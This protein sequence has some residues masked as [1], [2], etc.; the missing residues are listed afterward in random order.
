MILDL[1]GSGTTNVEADFLIIGAGTIGLP[2]AALLAKQ[3]NDKKVVILESG[4][5]KQLDISHPLNN[6][7]MHSDY[8]T[9]A[10]CGRF[11]CLGGTSTRWGGA[12]I[13][14]QSSDLLFEGWPT[15]LPP[16]EKYIHKVEEI[17]GLDKDAYEEEEFPFSVTED[18]VVRSAKWPPMKNLNVYSIFREECINLPN[19]NIWINATATN[20]NTRHSDHVEISAQSPGGDKIHV[21]ADRVIIAAGAIETTR[22]ALLIDQQNNKLISKVSSNL[23]HYFSDHI[24]VPIAAIKTNDTSLLNRAFGFHFVGNGRIRKPRIEMANDT[25]LR[26]RLP[27]SY[28]HIETKVDKPNGFDALREYYKSIQ[29]QRRPT[30]K[31]LTQLLQHTPWL[32]QA[33]WWR[34]V[35]K[36]LLFPSDATIEIHIVIQQNP[37]W[38]NRI[39]LSNTETDIFN[40]PLAEIEWNIGPVDIDNILQ[41]T[42]TYEGVWKSSNLSSLGEWSSFDNSRIVGKIINNEGYYHPTSST[43]MADDPSSGVVDTDLRLFSSPRI[44]LLATS[45]LPSGGGANPTMMLMCLGMRCVDQHIERTSTPH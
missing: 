36:C 38:N 39:T 20:F 18:F 11:R 12:L 37:D 27:P 15:N 41:T 14:F 42:Y 33:L 5:R 6:V 29:M 32:I 26:N 22:L 16:L 35:N 7:I 21:T 3:L 30:V 17:F 24:S 43:R 10:D 9:A 28:I 45:A 1:V 8:Y 31:T 40:L 19:L 25:E 13:P 34:Y 4:D 2:V 23:G 44:Q